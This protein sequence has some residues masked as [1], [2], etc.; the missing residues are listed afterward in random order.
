MIVDAALKGDHIETNRSLR[1]SVEEHDLKR[2]NSCRFFGSAT[3][4]PGSERTCSKIFVDME[5]KYT[6]I[7]SIVA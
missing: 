2:T 6:K 4:R 7:V 5:T 1:Q 3:G